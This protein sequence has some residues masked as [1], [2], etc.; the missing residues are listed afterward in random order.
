MTKRLEKLYEELAALEAAER[1]AMRNISAYTDEELD[2]MVEAI[3]AKEAEIDAEIANPT[4]DAQ[5]EPK[6]VEVT[7][8]N[9][10][11]LTALIFGAEEF[12]AMKERA[13]RRTEAALE[14]FKNE[15][16]EI[17]H[18]IDENNDIMSIEEA[19]QMTHKVLL[20]TVEFTQKPTDFEVGGIQNRLPESVAEVTIEELA[21]AIISGRTFKPNYMTGRSQSSFVSSSLIAIDIDNKGKELE[22]YG[23]ISIDDFKLKVKESNLKPAIIYT[24]FSHTDVCHKYRAIFQL[25]R[26]ITNLEELKAVGTAIKSEYPFADAKVSVVH[27]IYGGHNLIEVNPDAFID[28]DNNIIF[29]LIAQDIDIDETSIIDIKEAAR[30][31]KETTKLTKDTI[32]TDTLKNL[33]GYKT[34]ESYDDLKKHLLSINLADLLRVK[35]PSKFNCIFHNDK[36]PSAGIFEVNGEYIYNCFSGCEHGKKDIFNIVAK[37]K[38]F[39]GSASEQYMKATRYL[40]QS[41]SIKVRNEE[42]MQAQFTTIRENRLILTQNRINKDTYPALSP[43]MRYITNLLRAMLDHAEAAVMSYPT[44]DVTGQALFFVS[45]NQLSAML[46]GKQVRTIRTQIAE[47]T[48]LG[49]IRKVSDEE[50]EKVAPK[51][52]KLSLKYKL[53]NNLSHTVQ[54]YSIPLWNTDTLLRANEI[55]AQGNASGITSKGMGTRAASAINKTVST[56]VEYEE[57]DRVKADIEAM[58]KWTKRTLTRNGAVIK[59]DFVKYAKKKKIGARYAATILPGVIAK[60]ELKKITVTN[61]LIKKYSL[62]KNTLRK[63]AFAK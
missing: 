53:E 11:E 21:A 56:K 29:N 51:R 43:R 54:Y 15:I 45:Y 25:K 28:M 42:W 30:T 36:K 24:T 41:L 34:F 38:G 57:S 3:N 19:E 27:P 9:L 47:L 61:D 37:I 48:M 63:T 49:L 20:D 62:P 31:T 12:Q 60:L 35:N 1:E 5:E 8:D 59:D 32:I 22:E 40:M 58:L 50:V 7:M 18:E 10:E 14:A 6:T 44:K 26:L 46:E 55:K 23:Y 33:Y 16:E 2:S 13:A 17:M 4:K 39:E 52:F